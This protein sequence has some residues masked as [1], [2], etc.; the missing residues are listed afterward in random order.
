M[1]NLTL[2][3]SLRMFVDM[4]AKRLDENYNLIKKLRASVDF[5]FRNQESSFKALEMQVRTM[6]HP[7]GIAINVLVG[8]DKFTFPVDFIILDIPED[9]KTP[10]ILGRPFLSTAHAMIN[11]ECHNWIVLKKR[12]QKTMTNLTLKESLRMFMDMTAK[13]L[14]ENYNLI[15]KLRASV[16]FAF[17]NQES[18]IKA[19]EMQV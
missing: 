2:K 10:L 8:I 18:S 13:R 17:R 5:A 11:N 6:K 15:K 16:D 12:L 7:K 14:D 4:T 9:F 19:L 1:T 3:E